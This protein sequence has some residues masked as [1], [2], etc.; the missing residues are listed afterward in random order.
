LAD[1][2]PALELEVLALPLVSLPPVPL[3]LDELLSPDELLVV[4]ELDVPA[5]LVVDE[6]LPLSLLSA[7]RADPNVPAERLSVL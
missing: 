3:E 4:L 5:S 6:L 7:S 2:V 1:D